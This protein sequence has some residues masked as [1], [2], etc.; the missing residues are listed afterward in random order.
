MGKDLN[1]KK[2]QHFVPQFLQRYFSYNGNEKTIGMFNVNNKIFRLSAPIKTQLY[3]EYFYGK[4]GKLETWLSEL[5]SKSA[6]I[7]RA[8]WKTEKL[9]AYETISQLEMLHFLLILDLRNPIRFKCLQDFEELINNT[10]SGITEGNIPTD[11]IP[12]LKNLQNEDGKIKSLISAVKIVPDLTVLK[13]KLLKNTTNIPFIISDNPLVLYNQFLEKR[14]WNF[15]SQRGYGVKGL[16]MFLPINDQYLLILYDSIVYKVGCKKEIV[17]KI[18][19]QHSINQLNILQFLNSTDTINFNHKVS[20][21]Y[22]RTLYERSMRY[23]KANEVFIKVHGIYDGNGNVDS[24]REGIE[25]GV[26]DLKVNLSIQKIK[27]LSKSK[28]VKLDNSLVQLRKG[29]KLND[30]KTFAITTV[31]NNDLTQ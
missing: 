19:C 26:T 28:A 18:D 21:H 1:T 30:I 7:F 20:E 4:S 31:L 11:L 8:M 29:I 17:V 22:I 6:P 14:K 5:E 25:L 3:S 10:K 23:K 9:P 15:V 16:Q 2:N 13:Y 27:F 12:V 24:L